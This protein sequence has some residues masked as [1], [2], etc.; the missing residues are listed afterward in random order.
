MSPPFTR[1][2]SENRDIYIH[3]YIH[4]YVYNHLKHVLLTNIERSGVIISLSCEGSETSFPGVQMTVD[5][6]KAYLQQV[7][8]SFKRVTKPGTV[9]RAL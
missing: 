7:S 9:V 1:I 2:V 6:R 8:D 5:C 3:I 4:I